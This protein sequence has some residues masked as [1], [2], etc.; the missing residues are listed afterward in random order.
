MK[1]FLPEKMENKKKESPV[2]IKYHPGL[3][4]FFNPAEMVFLL[5]MSNFEYLKQSG[6][7][8]N[9]SKAQYAK[10][11]GMKEYTFEKCVIRFTELGMLSKSHNALG[12]VVYYSLKME[13]YEKLIR[14]IASTGRKQVAAFF[15][16]IKA[17][18]RSIES[19]SEEE[20]KALSA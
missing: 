2:F 3:S 6:Y 4:Y 18:S 9:L 8:V 16:S 17:E 11:M 20:I 19:I 1:I 13:L 5:Q 7:R 15:E 10:Q 12:N 14:I